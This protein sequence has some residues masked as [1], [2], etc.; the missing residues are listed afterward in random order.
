MLTTHTMP[1][2][3]IIKLLWC[4]TLTINQICGCTNCGQAT[5]GFQW[6]VALVSVWLAG[7]VRLG[8]FTRFAAKT[9]HSRIS[10]RDALFIA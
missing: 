3:T 4:S 10:V 7:Q 5:I 1:Y 8:H 6:R 2:F 9:G